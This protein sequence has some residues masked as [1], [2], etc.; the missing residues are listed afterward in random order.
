M[1]GVRPAPTG[2]LPRH[3]RQAR[4]VSPRGRAART[5]G[6]PA[7]RRRRRS[8]LSPRTCGRRRPANWRFPPA[9]AA[10]PSLT[11]TRPPGRRTRTNS[12]S[13]VGWSALG[14]CISAPSETTPSNRLSPNGSAAN[15]PAT[16][17]A[18]GTRLAASAS[19]SLEKSSPT[20]RLSLGSA[21]SASPGP[22]PA[23][24]TVAADP[25]PSTSRCSRASSTSSG[26][27]SAAYVSPRSS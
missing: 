14:T 21:A 13:T 1:L 16:R 23:S 25:T 9:H 5:H 24:S 10:P 6:R 19:C 27:R 22:Q 8:P 7:P 20:V 15:S 26:E 4:R 2:C 12:S 17:S 18:P 3:P 11:S